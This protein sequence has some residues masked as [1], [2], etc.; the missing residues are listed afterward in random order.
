MQLHSL[1]LFSLSN[2]IPLI[3]FAA[4][5]PTT[6]FYDPLM[7]TKYLAKA[8]TSV[9]KNRRLKDLHVKGRLIAVLVGLL[10]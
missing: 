4:E 2:I 5:W 10:A 6:Y 1:I 7:G 9:S 3:L 8:G